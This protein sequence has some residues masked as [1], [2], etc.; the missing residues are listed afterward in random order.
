MGKFCRDFLR[1][2]P[3]KRRSKMT[4]K[5]SV[6]VP[7]HW[8]DPLSPARRRLP[9]AVSHKMFHLVTL[10]LVEFTSVLPRDEGSIVNTVSERYCGCSCSVI[11]LSSPTSHSL[12]LFKAESYCDMAHSLDLEHPMT[13]R[14]SQ[15]SGNLQQSPTERYLLRIIN[16]SQH[17]C[18]RR[19]LVSRKHREISL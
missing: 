19:H 17:R 3:T 11:F 16:S 1:N 15:H 10:S 7:W 6:T 2:G 8:F 9:S 5:S 13:R 4:N 14:Q 12:P 18:A